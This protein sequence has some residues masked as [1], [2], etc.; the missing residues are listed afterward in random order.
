MST[1]KTLKSVIEAFQ[2]DYALVD[3][4]IKLAQLIHD[5]TDEEYK[6]S[7]EEIKDTVAVRNSYWGVECKS[8]VQSLFKSDIIDI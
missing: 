8:K 2:D 7:F 6:A 4:C 3:D 5:A 1:T